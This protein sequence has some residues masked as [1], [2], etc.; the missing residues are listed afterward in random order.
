[1]DEWSSSMGREIKGIALY[2]E[3]KVTPPNLLV[4]FSQVLF[5]EINKRRS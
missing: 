5:H 3:D 4:Y 1:M 2:S